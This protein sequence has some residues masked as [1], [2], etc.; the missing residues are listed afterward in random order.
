M[1]PAEFVRSRMG[2]PAQDWACAKLVGD[3]ITHRTGRDPLAVYGRPIE[4]GERWLQERG[5]LAVAV[6]RVM[7]ANGFPKTLTPMPGDAGLI[8]ADGNRL[9]AALRTDKWWISQSRTGWIA[10]PIAWKAWHIPGGAE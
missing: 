8:L 2:Q 3:W 5:G 6:N 9:C 7:R 1:T 4:D 10:Q